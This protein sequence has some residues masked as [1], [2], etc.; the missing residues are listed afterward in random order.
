MPLEEQATQ[1]VKEGTEL[2]ARAAIQLTARGAQA[3]IQAV[4]GASKA[5]AHKT[6]QTIKKQKTT[7]K[8]SLKNLNQKTGGSTSRLDLDL[9][10]AQE[11]SKALKKAGVD[12]NISQ[13]KKNDTAVVTFPLQASQF[14]QDTLSRTHTN[15]S[16]DDI[17]Q[18][19]A[20]AKETVTELNNPDMEKVD[21]Q[22]LAREET[23][24]Q[25]AGIIVE[26]ESEPV[27]DQ[28]PDYW[29]ATPATTKQKDLIRE[30][31]SQ[32]FIENNEA[33]EFLQSNPTIA[34]ANEFLN[35]HPETV[36]HLD[37]YGKDNVDSL[38]KNTKGRKISR[39]EVQKA[40]KNGAKARTRRHT[41]TTPQRQQSLKKS[42][43]LKK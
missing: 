35:N 36:D 15:M 13:N 19:I 34:D 11:L 37:L 16:R 30:Q 24:L 31:A 2:V 10:Q 27:H 14:V 21:E 8:M 12:F 32:G 22:S 3:F 42:T 40:V 17:N 1:A 39:K 25:E 6:H 33:Q 18:T 4:F 9:N 41:A 20:D 26:A 5:A 43:T 38:K 29:Q 23:E 28:Q 7:G